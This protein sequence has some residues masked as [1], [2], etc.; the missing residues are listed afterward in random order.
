MSALHRIAF[1]ETRPLAPVPAKAVLGRLPLERVLPQDTHSVV[2][3]VAAGAYFLSA[4]LARTKRGRVMGLL[5]GTKVLGTSVLTDCR[6]SIAKVIPIELHEIVDHVAGSS[7]IAAPLAL[8]YVARDPAASILQMATGAVV[9]AASLFT[10]YRAV[11]GV[12]RAV[13]SQ[14]GPAP[15]RMPRRPRV[16]E[17]QRPLEGLAAPS[18]LPTENL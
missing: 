15:H 16:A 12:G 18:M 8:G 10:D 3:Y 9:L 14:G 11:R 1:A 17:A 6:L 7:A 2:D 5:L 4:A 13:R